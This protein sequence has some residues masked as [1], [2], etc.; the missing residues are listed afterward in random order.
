MTEKSTTP[1]NNP[2]FWQGLLKFHEKLFELAQFRKNLFFYGMGTFLAAILISLIIAILGFIPYVVIP[3]LTG[4]NPSVFQTDLVNNSMGDNPS[5]FSTL[6]GSYLISLCPNLVI[7][8]IALVLVSG[9][10]IVFQNERSMVQ[11]LDILLDKDAPTS[12]RQIA[13]ESLDK[14]GELT[15][16]RLKGKSFVK[17]HLPNY[18]WK[19]ANLQ[20]VTFTNGDLSGCN[21]RGTNLQGAIFKGVDLKDTDFS[22][23][24]MTDVDMEGAKNA[25]TIRFTIDTKL[26]IDSNNMQNK[27]HDPEKFDEIKRKALKELTQNSSDF[28]WRKR[29]W[30]RFTKETRRVEIPSEGSSDDEKVI[31]ALRTKYDTLVEEFKCTASMTG[32]HI[33]ATAYVRRSIWFPAFLEI[34]NENA[35][36]YDDLRKKYWDAHTYALSRKIQITRIFVIESEEDLN[37]KVI[38]SEGSETVRNFIEG[39]DAT[40]GLETGI[41]KLESFNSP[42]AAAINSGTEDFIIFADGDNLRCYLL[43]NIEATTVGSIIHAQEQVY[44]RLEAFKWLLDNHNIR[45]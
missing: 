44:S 34:T 31:I 2:S 28:M 17:L 42:S 1:I 11:L 21:F 24:D 43:S 8:F 13:L 38:N 40:P 36:V 7:V 20:S 39:Q 41:C 32:A 37:Q 30:C 6:L 16:G 14:R 29:L 19:S 18:D 4:F 3:L 5:L 12:D 15:K 9:W 22:D 25:E 26:P 23:V 35:T 45:L 27:P 10:W 33:Y